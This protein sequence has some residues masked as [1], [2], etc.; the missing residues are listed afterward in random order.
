LKITKRERTHIHVRLALDVHF[1]QTKEKIL[2]K[3][4]S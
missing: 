2:C 1:T 3:V 4:A